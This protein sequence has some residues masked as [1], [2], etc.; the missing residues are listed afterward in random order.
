MPT[1]HLSLPD[2]DYKNLVGHRL[3]NMLDDIF[4]VKSN[5]AVSSLKGKSYNF[6]DRLQCKRIRHVFIEHTTLFVSYR[7][8]NKILLQCP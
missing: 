3:Y 2:L 1:L 7:D 8:V 5:M 6:N 4:H